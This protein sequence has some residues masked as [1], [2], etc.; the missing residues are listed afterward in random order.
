MRAELR[1]PGEVRGVEQFR[2]EAAHPHRVPHREHLFTHLYRELLAIV[3]GRVPAHGPP[4]KAR[5]VRGV[6][7]DAG[8]DLQRHA[9]PQVVEAPR[10]HREPEGEG[11]Q[12][13]GVVGVGLHRAL[14]GH[15][16]PQGLL[17]VE[18]PLH[19]VAPRRDGPP[20]ALVGGREEQ[21]L[22]DGLRVPP[23]QVE[24]A[25]VVR[26]EEPPLVEFHG[27]AQTAARPGGVQPQVVAHVVQVHDDLRRLHADVRAE[28]AHGHVLGA[29]PR[30]V[31]LPV[32]AQ[33]VHVLHE[34]LQL[35]VLGEDGGRVVQGAAVHRT[36]EAARHPG[37]EV[38][39]GVRVQLGDPGGLLVV[40][41]PHGPDH[42]GGLVEERGAHLVE[43]LPHAGA[44][45]LGGDLLVLRRDLLGGGVPHPLEA[46]G[47]HG[48]QVQ[49]AH[50]RPRAPAG[51]DG[52]RPRHDPGG[53]GAVLPR[54]GDVHHRQV[55]APTAVEFLLDAGAG[56]DVVQAPVGRGVPELDLAL[57]DVQERGAVR[58][59]VEDQVVDAVELQER[60][61][62]VPRVRVHEDAAV[63]GPGGEVP[64]GGAG[65]DAGGQARA[66]DDGDLRVQGLESWVQEVR[67]VEHV[68]AAASQEGVHDLAGGVRGADV[69]P[70][71]VH[72][73]GAS[74]ARELG[75]RR[76]PAQEPVHPLLNHRR[77]EGGRGL[78]RFREGARR[79][80]A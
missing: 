1:I 36:P 69:L 67:E 43:D 66:V 16:V 42:A 38:A 15:P 44:H 68:H 49:G 11:L 35:R 9:V 28:L 29:V 17:R 18:A 34:G 4:V 52:L 70:G 37:A 45:E 39:V 40:L 19:G 75:L 26:G 71:Q 48:L 72:E 57:V 23:A 12:D 20:E 3:R 13:P 24:A 47:D 32:V 79:W 53:E 74:L 50:L 31:S 25:G 65:D 33:A 27:P 56:V 58:L 22:G 2:R 54:P 14:H 5:F 8:V 7:V 60:G 78:K 6:V 51:V 76:H 21:E 41:R 64:A 73:Q 46:V 63:G 10:R 77:W 55:G 80:A 61:E 30:Q 59:P 62:V